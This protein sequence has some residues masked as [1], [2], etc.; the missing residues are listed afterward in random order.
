M[1]KFF[2]EKI[3]TTND[4]IIDAAL[5]EIYDYSPHWWSYNKKLKIK[6][7]DKFYNENKNEQVTDE[8]LATL[9]VKM[10]TELTEKIESLRRG[11]YDENDVNKHYDYTPKEIYEHI[12]AFVKEYK[13]RSENIRSYKVE[14]GYYRTIGDDGYPLKEPEYVPNLAQTSHENSR[15]EKRLKKISD[16]VARAREDVT[17]EMN[18]ANLELR[19]GNNYFYPRKSENYENLDDPEYHKAVDCFLKFIPLAFRHHLPEENIASCRYKLKN[20]LVDPNKFYQLSKEQVCDAIY[21]LPLKDQLMIIE[22]CLDRDTELGKKMWKKRGLRDCSLESG[23]LERLCKHAKRL[24]KQGKD[25][26]EAAEKKEA[27]RELHASEDSDVKKPT[28]G[29]RRK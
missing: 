20:V 23:T 5:K 26:V 4:A 6:Q 21:K 18:F 17:E 22:R 3:L 12:E 9:K 15:F 27:K 25:I 2:K 14:G 29:N 7:A 16:V 11:Y 28:L 8:E 13:K 24:G 10:A 19:K 1:V